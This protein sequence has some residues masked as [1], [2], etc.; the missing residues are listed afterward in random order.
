[1]SCGDGDKGQTLGYG[2]NIIENVIIDYVA[3][4]EGLKHNILSVNQIC[5]KGYHVDF[6]ESHCE[7]I[8]NTTKKIVII[9]F[10]HV[11]IS[12]ANLNLNSGGSI[13][14]LLSKA[15]VEESWNWHKRLSHLNFSNLNELVKKYLARGLPKVQFVPDKICDSCQKAKQS[16]VSFKSKTE[17]SI[18][19]PY[20]LLHLYLFGL[21][22][23]MYMSKKRYALVI[24]DDYTRYAWVYFL[25]KRDE[26]P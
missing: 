15:S 10:R 3:L 12:E 24:L 23:I 14:Y 1:M 5:D 22:N 20:H 25:H 7:V 26:T 16:R 9:G 18:S 6:V 17:S 2:N 19:Y 11:N 8:S 4:V 21:L 13:T